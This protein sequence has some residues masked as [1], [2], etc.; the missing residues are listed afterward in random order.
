[1]TV[2][3]EVKVVTADSAIASSRTAPRSR[4][5]LGIEGMSDLTRPYSSLTWGRDVLPN[6]SVLDCHRSDN[7]LAIGADDVDRTRP[8]GAR[9]RPTPTARGGPPAAIAGT[10][11]CRS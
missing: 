4:S 8:T 7:I 11:P 6:V 3:A 2:L 9:L 10:W 1:M 5:L